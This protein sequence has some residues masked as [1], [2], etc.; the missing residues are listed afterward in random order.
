M[1]LLAE[2]SIMINMR[3][4]LTSFL[5]LLILTPS[6]AC[7]MPTCADDKQQ[8][9]AKNQPC[10]DRHSEH[11]KDNKDSSTVNFVVDCMGVDM[12]LA[13]TTSLDKPDFK[14]DVVIY[15]FAADVLNNPLIQTKADTIRGPP[16][17]LLSRY[18]TQPSIIL[19]T[20]RYRI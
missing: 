2:Y 14:T 5:L 12:Q 20:Q 18:E 9:E 16:P 13:D 17:D 11:G 10:A 15:A 3:L 1:A 6:L 4:L 8:V 19:T 7:A